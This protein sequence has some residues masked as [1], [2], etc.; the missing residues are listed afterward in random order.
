MSL[1]DAIEHLVFKPLDMNNTY[2]CPSIDKKILCAPTEYSPHFYKLLWG[3]AHDRKAY[4]QN[5]VSGHAGI[6]SCSED[7]SHYMKMILNGGIWNDQ[8]FLPLDLI[9]DMYTC[10]TPKGEISRGIG[11]L[12]FDLE[13][14][15]SKRNSTRS[16]MH[17]GFTGTSLLFDIDNNTGILVLSNRVY[18]TR[19]NRR[20]L[21]WRKEFHECVMN[22]LLK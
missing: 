2:Y 17:T 10:K 20:I 13:S 8:V 12:T 21:T 1:D 16:C 6:F 19:N 9:K 5:G 15:F 3:E 14:P 22:L 7:L 11:Y 4:L 18:P